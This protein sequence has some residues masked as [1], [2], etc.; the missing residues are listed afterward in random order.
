MQKDTLIVIDAFLSAENRIQACHK[1]INQIREACPEYKIMLL[2]KYSDSGNL[3]SLVDYYFYYGDGKLVGT[4][5]Q[6]LL[7]TGL[8]ERPYVYVT[9][10]LGT[11]QNWLPLTGFQDHVGSVVNGFILSSRFAK[12]LGYKK[13]FQIEYDTDFDIEELTNLKKDFETFEDYLLL[14]KRFEQSEKYITDVH[15]LGYSVNLFNQFDLVRSDKEWWELC[16]KINYYGKTAEYVI[17]AMLEYLSKFNTL[18]GTVY[19]G[20]CGLTFPNTK[21]DTINGKGYW[22]EKWKDIPKICIKAENNWIS[23]TDEVVLFY[24]NDNQ[25]DLEVNCKVVDES[26]NE[27][28]SKQVIL[29]PRHWI[30]D[31]IPLNGLLTLFTENKQGEEIRNYSSSFSANTINNFPCRFIFNEGNI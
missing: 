17:P 19:E 14:G 9:T 23:Y 25:E 22:T 11:C 29:K 5:P 6:E 24:W 28:Y 31:K 30:L 4:P 13:V 18:N 26:G 12:A 21:F 3:D 16:K 10:S 15:A 1:L 20:Y 7:E 2:N 27:V 8:Y